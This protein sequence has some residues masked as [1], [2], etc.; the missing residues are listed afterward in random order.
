MSHTRE[1]KIEA[2]GRFIDILDILREKCPWDHKQTNES[3]R[4]NTI[5]ETYELCDALIRKD[6]E[7]TKKELGD[8]LLHI[9]FYAKIGEENGS[10]D[11]ADVCNA[12]CEKLI[13]TLMYSV[14][15][16]SMDRTRLSKIGR[17]SN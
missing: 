5:E 14:Q 12:L 11:I 17:N 8:V 7:A 9:A 10:F 4:P 13:A 2:F 15:P 1:E 16:M 3:L 6:N